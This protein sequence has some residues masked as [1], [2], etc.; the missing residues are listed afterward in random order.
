[1]KMICHIGMMKAASTFLQRVLCALEEPELLPRGIYPWL[2][3]SI[4][5]FPFYAPHVF[6]AVWEKYR[7]EGRLGFEFQRILNR[8]FH[9]EYPVNIYAIAEYLAL[10]ADKDST[11]SLNRDLL[12]VLANSS[13]Q[14]VLCS[15]EDFACAGLRHCHSAE[16]LLQKRDRTMSLLKILFEQMDVTLILVIRRQDKLMRSLYNTLVSNHLVTAPLMEVF[17]RFER[18]LHYDR[19]VERLIK[20]YGA[21]RVRILFFEEI[22]EDA[23]RFVE[24]F[25]QIVIPDVQISKEAAVPHVNTSLSPAAFRIMRYANAVLRDKYDTDEALLPSRVSVELEKERS[26]LKG[27]LETFTAVPSETESYGLCAHEEQQLMA[28]Y[29]EGNRRLFDEYIPP[30]SPDHKWRRCYLGESS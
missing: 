8:A 3:D 24:R 5:R 29:L 25:L 4:P 17:S 7:Q 10:F 30:G 12:E 11:R 22:K 18:L 2:V 14:T 1:M 6:Q 16:E 28:T 13:V 20:L 15:H 23:H 9:H 27:V 21:E 26:A 19:L